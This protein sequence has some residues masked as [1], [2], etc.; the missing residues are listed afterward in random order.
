VAST[1]VVATGAT[2]G[3]AAVVAAVV[4]A[5]FLA[6]FSAGAAATGAATGAATTGAA[7][8]GAAAFFETVFLEAGAEEVV[9]I[10]T[11]AVEV[12]MAGIRTFNK[13]GHSIFE[14]TFAGAIF[15]W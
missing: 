2:A 6:F 14:A 15:L 3:V 5:D 9:F 11:E 1:A 12:F 7:T 8:A 13:N 4:A 10:I